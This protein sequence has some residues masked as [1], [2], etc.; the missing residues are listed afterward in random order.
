MSNGSSR[1][2]YRNPVFLGVIGAVIAAIIATIIGATWT[3]WLNPPPSDFSISINP[4]QGAVH[5]GGVITTAV[6]IKGVS[7]Y[8][9][10][11]GLSATEQP[12]GVVLA[13]VPQSGEAKPSYT[14]SVTITVNSNV[15]V[16]DYRITING[17]G[18]DGKE[19]RCDY[20]LTVKPS[21][22]ST[23]TPT[24]T[25]GFPQLNIIHTTLLEEPQIGEEG[26]VTV[27]IHNQGNGMA[28][29]I[30]LTESIPSSISVSSVG[31]ASSSS[32]NLVIWSG[33]LEPGEVHSITHTFKILEER[34]I[35]FPAKATFKDEYG[36]IYETSS[37]ISVMAE[38]PTPPPT[39]TSGPE[40]EPTPIPT[41]SPWPTPT[42][43]PE[44]EPT[45]IPTLPPWPTPTSG[46]EQELTPILTPTPLLETIDTMDSISG[47][48]RVQDNM[49]S[50]IN[51]ESVPGRT[52]NGINISY[53]LKRGG[54]VLISKKIDPE[55]NLSKY[56]GVRFYYKG[57]GGP[58]TIELK[59]IYEDDTTFGVRWHRATV[60]DNWVTREA[61][62]SDYDLDLDLAKV[63]KIEFAISNS[64]EDEY[65]SGWVI[66]DDVQGIMS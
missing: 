12:S 18:A 3:F 30:T 5:Q 41:L 51:I 47:W 44:Q 14:S 66:I 38:G 4:M 55:I 25:I 64:R 63:K 9:E 11:V 21:V 7:G 42:S 52:D 56:S 34:R 60:A 31:G 58:N 2:W 36:K 32:G 59:L 20:T 27:S 26:L 62:Y 61:P 35:F 48:R 46:P 54:W 22:T 57:S 53:D 65:G 24:S 50:T 17:I 23:P 6:T 8:E 43:G 37:T 10:R 16:G 19:H 39:P 40:Q 28:K 13:F 1:P 29:N 33:E 45:P 15:P 49:G